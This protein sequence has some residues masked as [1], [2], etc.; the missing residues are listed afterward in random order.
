MLLLKNVVCLFYPVQFITYWTCYLKCFCFHCS[1]VTAWYI[2][3]YCVFIVM[4]RIMHYSPE[5]V[6]RMTV[7]I[8]IFVFVTLVYQRLVGLQLSV[9]SS[10]SVLCKCLLSLIFICFD[11]NF[12]VIKTHRMSYKLMCNVTDLKTYWNNGIQE[13]VLKTSDIIACILLL[14]EKSIFSMEK[15]V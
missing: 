13:Y 15:V 11:V 12:G 2:V 10:L 14:S 7:S 3:Y 5:R 4:Q 9:R 8:K 6:T 1:I